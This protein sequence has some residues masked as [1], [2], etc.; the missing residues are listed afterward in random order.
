MKKVKTQTSVVAAVAV[1]LLVVFGAGLAA[2]AAGFLPQSTYDRLRERR[3][4]QY[5]QEHKQKQ[6]WLKK[7]AEA[8]YQLDRRRRLWY[9]Q[10]GGGGSA[11]Y[12]T[13]GYDTPGY[14]TPGYETPGYDTPGYDTPGYETP[15]YQFP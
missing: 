11:G 2:Y 15:G 12:D 9:G 6:E 5:S 14:E 4:E 7:K 3:L 13:P 8:K 10:K 1:A